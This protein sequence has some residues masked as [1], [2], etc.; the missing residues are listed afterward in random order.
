MNLIPLGIVTDHVKGRSWEFGFTPEYLDAQHRK[1]VTEHYRRA[2]EDG[3]YI[4][5]IR[6]S[7][8]DSNKSYAARSD[9]CEGTG[10]KD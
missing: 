6:A 4:G 7:N 3:E 8:Q 10:Q 9:I 2:R 5:F 1:R